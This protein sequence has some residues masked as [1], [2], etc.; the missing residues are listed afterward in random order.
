MSGSLCFSDYSNKVD[1]LFHGLCGHGWIVVG[2]D[3]ELQD[4]FA[5]Y[6]RSGTWTPEYFVMWFIDKYDLMTIDESFYN[7]H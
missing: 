5:E 2:S 1:E 4:A 6:R 7:C 3:E